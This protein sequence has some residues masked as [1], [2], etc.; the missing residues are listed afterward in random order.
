MDVTQLLESCRQYRTAEAALAK[1][2]RLPLA[3]KQAEIYGEVIA[4]AKHYFCDHAPPH[5]HGFELVELAAFLMSE[6]PVEPELAA[7]LYAAIGEQPVKHRLDVFC[8]FA[9]HARDRRALPVLRGKWY[10]L[11][12]ADTVL[13]LQ[14]RELLED[15]EY[16]L[17]RS[18]YRETSTGLAIA[19]GYLGGEPVRSALL[20]LHASSHGGGDRYGLG[21]A[22][23]ADPRDAAWFA[24]LEGLEALTARR[25]HTLLSSTRAKERLAAVDKLGRDIELARASVSPARLLALTRVLTD[26]D[27]LLVERAAGYLLDYARGH[28][29]RATNLFHA[30]FLVQAR[31]AIAGGVTAL[32]REHLDAMCARIPRA[33]PLPAGELEVAP[34]PKPTAKVVAQR[35]GAAMLA[36]LRVT[37]PASPAVEHDPELEA[38]IVEDPTDAGRYL[39]YADWLQT[40]NDPRGTLIALDHAARVSGDPAHLVAA[41]ALRYEHPGAFFGMLEPYTR[42]RDGRTP[43]HLDWFMGFIKGARIRLDNDARH[44]AQLLA[45][46]GYLFDCPSA[47]FLQELV[48]E[49]PGA[50]RE[51]DTAAIIAVL[52]A[53]RPPTLAMLGKPGSWQVPPALRVAFPRLQRDPAAAWAEVMDR[54]AEQRRLKVE[55]AASELPALEPRV[56]GIAIA[57]EAVLVGLKA[58]LDKLRP[59]GLLA[60]MP[61]VFAAESL[62]RFALAMAHQ[63]QARGE[64]PRWPFDALGPLGGDRC[65]GFLAANLPSWSHQRALQALDHLARIGSDLAIHAIAELVLSAR[66][67]GA[68]RGA[69][70]DVLERIAEAR[71]LAGRAQLLDRVCP[72]PPPGA[73]R[74]HVVETQ[75]HWLQAI[76]LSG[77]RIALADFR[78]FVAGHALRRSLASTLLWA[79]CVGSQLVALLRVSATGELRRTTGAPYE[80]TQLGATGHG[81]GLVHPAELEAAELAAVRAGFAGTEQAILQLDRPVLRLAPDDARRQTLHHFEPRRVG[82]YALEAALEQRGWI[83]HDRDERG[84]TQAFGRVFERDQVVAIARLGSGQGSV[85]EVEVS[86]IGS[87]LER[88]RFD[89]LHPVTLSELLW[90]LETAHGGAVAASRAAG[91][92]VPTSTSPVVERAKSGRARCVVCAATITKASLRIGIERLIETPA[93]SG[94]ATVW[95][96]PHCRDGVPE[97]AGARGLDEL[98]AAL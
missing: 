42:E 71:G 60:T 74:A 52:L 75:R 8:R 61:R 79:E 22:F 30:D 26:A 21:L 67:V 93:F 17:E 31:Q 56:H 90:D 34:P 27:L 59:L 29:D 95:V 81:I 33:H 28:G 86:P 54:V 36:E 4:L 83:A 20:R 37:L 7:R 72:E 49:A 13:A 18:Q 39:V 96:H 69:G 78:Q 44:D 82:F 41:D 9:A 32:A 12:W 35:R 89:R 66:S 16:G 10:Q 98:L 62:D 15:I 11:E 85:G 19:A 64:T 25:V 88:R 5:A 57:P 91:S 97:L 84:I 51:L 53:R 38:V 94:L 48:I 6:L 24:A 47:R 55:L 77:H 73:L 70:C 92:A 58:E 43:V 63:W 45:V 50:R 3:R 80:A 46:L 1:L 40:R 87:Y 65:V 68:R 2:A 76:M 14:G 23:L